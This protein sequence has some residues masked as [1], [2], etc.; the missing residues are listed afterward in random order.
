MFSRFPVSYVRTRIPDPDDVE[1]TD[2]IDPANEDSSPSHSLDRAH[3]QVGGAYNQYHMSALGPYYIPPQNP[4]PYPATENYQRVSCKYDNCSHMFGVDLSYE[5]LSAHLKDVHNVRNEPLS[6][7]SMT[8]LWEGCGRVFLKSMITFH[9]HHDHSLAQ[10]YV[11]SA[12][13]RSRRNAVVA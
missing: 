3:G 8:C 13:Y 11:N 10:Q 7:E 4:A 9:I 1:D 2:A 5:E 12:Q 6:K